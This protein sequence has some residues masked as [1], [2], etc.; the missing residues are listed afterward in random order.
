MNCRQSHKAVIP[1]GKKFPYTEAEEVRG[2]FLA[3]ENYCTIPLP[4]YYEFQR[5]FNDVKLRMMGRTLE[6]C[7]KPGMLMRRCKGVNY[8]LPSS[9]D[10]GYAWREFRLI[11]PVVYLEMAR[12]FYKKSC[13]KD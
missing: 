13:K 8:V 7:V 4:S 6:D 9:K 2:Y 5:I 12:I 1:W 10:G 11:H 3:P